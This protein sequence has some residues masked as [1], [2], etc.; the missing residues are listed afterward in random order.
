MSFREVMASLLSE[1]EE[2]SKILDEVQASSRKVVLLSKQAVMAMH[3]Q[4]HVEAATKLSGAEAI[5]RRLETALSTSALQDGPA[6]TAY[7]EY[8]EAKILLASVK[9]ERLPSPREIGVPT[10]PYVLGLADAI[11]EFRRSAIEALRRGEIGKAES[12]LRLMEEVYQELLPFQDFYH[13]ISELRRKLDVSRHLI[14]LTLSDVSSEHRR[15]SLERAISNLEKRIG[16][17][18]SET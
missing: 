10:I 3:R 9:E 13:L 11:G 14:E 17:D 18:E 8:A 7:Q 4:N 12:C 5:L 16:V 6:R 1:F 2:K 15:Y